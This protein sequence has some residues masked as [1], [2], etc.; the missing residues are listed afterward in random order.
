[1]RFK[2]FIYEDAAETE[3]TRSKLLADIRKN[4]A[5]FFREADGHA[6]YRGVPKPVL[7]DRDI[8][9][10]NHPENRDAKDSPTA[11]NIFFNAMMEATLGIKD[12]RRQTMF[13][14]GS[15]MTAN[16]YGK[17][18]YCFPVGKF[19]FIW[20][21]KVADSYAEENIIFDNLRQV[22]E[23]EEV[24]DFGKRF[25]TYASMKSAIRS[26]FNS[27]DETFDILDPTPTVRDRI[28][29]SYN[30]AYAAMQRGG[31]EEDESFDFSSLLIKCM[32]ALGKRI[33][34]E[35]DLV[36]AIQSK[37]EILIY[38]SG[39]YYLIPVDSARRMVAKTKDTY[40]MN[41]EEVYAELLKLIEGAEA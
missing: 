30:T 9:L 33:Y 28:N 17:A 41:D 18:C 3:E 39:G 12:I 13:A 32:P 26:L 25:G 10:F 8:V 16:A 36:G 19:D 27:I 2:Q 35:E 7:A 31:D 14:T 6:L 5:E 40:H 34:I 29:R 38:K 11:F 1:M 4:C 24:P 22:I 21:S 20:S 37:H 23:K 15:S